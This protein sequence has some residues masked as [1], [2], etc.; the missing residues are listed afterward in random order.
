MLKMWLRRCWSWW[1]SSEV[2]E[3]S[4]LAFWQGWQGLLVSLFGNQTL[5]VSTN[6]ANCVILRYYHPLS[7]QRLQADA[8]S[9]GA[10]LFF[11]CHGVPLPVR[12]SNTSEP[13]RFRKL[14]NFVVL[15]PLKSAT[16]FGPTR[17][18]KVRVSFLE[19]DRFNICVNQAHIGCSARKEFLLL[20][21][22]HP[23]SQQRLLGRRALQRC[24]LLF[25][26]YHS[27]IWCF[28]KSAK[29]N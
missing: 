25:C 5:H 8:H 14:C 28:A 16:T 24:A 21:Y 1:L 27:R 2:G 17:T 26:V 6:S 23:L 4:S 18:Q 19:T 22:Y 3:V 9:K 20:P 29:R 7:Q 15:P 10:R 13:H 11:I 12:K